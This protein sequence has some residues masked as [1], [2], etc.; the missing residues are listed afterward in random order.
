MLAAAFFVITPSAAASGSSDELDVAVHLPDAPPGESFRR[1]I[2]ARLS[3][4][5]EVTSNGMFDQGDPDGSG[6]AVISVSE[7]FDVLCYTLEVRGI[8]PSTGAHIHEAPIT[9]AGPVV[10][11]LQAP[12]NGSSQECTAPA[13]SMDLRDLVENPQNYYVNVHNEPFPAGAVRGQ[14]SA[15]ASSDYVVDE[16]GRTAAVP[17]S[18][19]T[20]TGPIQGLGGPAVALSAT[21]TDTGFWVAS[22]NG[23]VYTFGNAQFF[24]SL[25]GRPLSA[26]IVGMASTPTGRGYWLAA[27]D[28]G[29]F[30]FGDARFF[31]SMGGT[32][33]NQPIVD[34]AATPTGRGYWLV[35]A[36]GGVFAFGDATFYGST[37]AM[38]LNQPI[39]GIVAEPLGDGYT[40]VASDGG[41]FTFGGATFYGST[42]GMRLNRPIV[43]IVQSATGQGYRLLG[44]DGGIFAF[45]DADFLGSAVGFSPDRL[46]AID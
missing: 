44:A 25:A 33:L 9:A 5:A 41:I 11:P 13:P 39:I 26:P 6:L 19:E 34:I 12:T 23:G 35:A 18:V 10:Q 7:D 36:D 46:V 37:G 17:G 8:A 20:R 28:G 3:G 40:L 43:D 45:G 15:D 30:A 24:G 2:T 27:A 22:A 21:P 31:G 42:G 38:R 1:P 14:T 32:R 4:M 16:R 29:V